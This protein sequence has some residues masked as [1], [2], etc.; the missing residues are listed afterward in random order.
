MLLCCQALAQ[1][2]AGASFNYK[3]EIPEAGFGVFVSRNLPVQFASFGIKARFG[4]DVYF[5]KENDKTNINTDIHADLIS[6]F[7]YRYLHPYFVLR[8]GGNHYSIND[9]KKYI[10]LLGSGTGIK[11]PVSAMV[12]P[13]I[14]INL[15]KYFTDFNENLTMRSISSLQMAGRAGIIIQI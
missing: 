13:F 14:E 1:W 2:E 7:F 5:Y 4:G 11:F 12:R 15:I 10:F 3:N 9:F 8:I 6:T